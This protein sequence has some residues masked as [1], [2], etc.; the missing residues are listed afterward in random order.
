V[1]QAGLSVRA[2]GDDDPGACRSRRTTVAPADQRDVFMGIALGLVFHFVGRLFASLGALNNWQPLFSA[3][4][5]TGLSAV[6]GWRCCGG[7]KEDK[8][9]RCV[10]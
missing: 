4:A 6:G 3:T 10:P 1:E 7:P 9:V 5:M 2:A 8:A